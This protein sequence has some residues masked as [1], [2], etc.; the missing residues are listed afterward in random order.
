M[1]MLYKFRSVLS[2]EMNE[3]LELLRV[4][5]RYTA[6]IESSL[7]SLD[8]YLVE[9]NQE[10]KILATNLITGWLAEKSVKNITKAGILS[11]VKGFARYLS[12]F[13]IKWEIPEYPIVE[14][15]YIPYIFSYEEFARIVIAA[16]NFGY[17][18]I[19]RPIRATKVFPVLLR[20]LYSCGLRL[21]EGLRLEWEN[22]DLEN[23]IITIREAKNM[24]Q[25]IVP[26]DRT[27]TDL[28][29]QYKRKVEHE[30]ICTRYLFESNYAPHK[31]FKNNSFYD[32]FIRILKAAGISYSKHNRLERGPSPHCLRHTF[33]LHSFLKSE[34][35]GI[36]Y[37]NA[38]SFLAAYLGHDSP[39]QTDK[40]L[41]ASH[42]VYT[43][44]H[45]RMDNYI[46][47][48]FPKIDFDEE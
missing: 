23:G 42:T 43:A 16:D 39:K 21:G 32:W 24:K 37:E 12:S 26:M 28:L 25:R 47:N 2:A 8:C 20:V 13:G 14:N 3:Y 27:L 5:G 19:R 41:K 36:K 17:G 1:K 4:A 10:N 29:E 40:Y 15:D 31:P 45:E 35:D 44:S 7:K 30:G 33:V 48:V 38:S 34:K 9:H 6:Q 22:I 18:V 11:N 46:G